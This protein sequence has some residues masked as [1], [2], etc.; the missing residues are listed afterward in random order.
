[1]L[2]EGDRVR[3]RGDHQVKVHG[4]RVELG[5]ID[6]RAARGRPGDAVVLLRDEQPAA[7]GFKVMRP[8]IDPSTVPVLR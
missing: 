6:G 5:E 7:F 4:Y 1:M 3:G 2:P 8:F